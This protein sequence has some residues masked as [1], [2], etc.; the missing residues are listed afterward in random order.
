MRSLGSFSGALALFSV[1]SVSSVFAGGCSSSV[2]TGSPDAGTDSGPAMGGD[3]GGSGD[4][5]GTL[6]FQPSNI[7]IDSVT[8][9]AAMAQPEDIESACTIQTIQA[10]LGSC[11]MSPIVTTT[12]PF[13]AGQTQNVA[14]IVVQSL[15]LGSNAVIAVEGDLPLVIVSLGDV[16]LNSNSSIQAN[17]A[18]ATDELGPG[19]AAAQGNSSTKG[20]GPGGGTAGNTTTNLGAGGGAFCG[21]GGPGGGV[22]APSGMAYGSADVR[23]LQGGSAGGAGTG[24]PGGSG[25]GGGAIQI[26]AMGTLTVNGTAYITAG[27]GGASGCIGFGCSAGGSGGSILLEAMN[28]TIA[29]ILA[30]NGGGGGSNVAGGSDALPLSG[31]TAPTAAPGGAAA[32]GSAAPGGNGSAGA[33]SAGAA[34]G[35]GTLSS[36]NPLGSVPGGGGGGAGW[37]R[38][39]SSSGAATLT[40]GTLSPDATTTCTTQGKVRTISQGP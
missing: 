28:V 31:G 6:A 17:T 2:S 12:E 19:G 40:G 14:L 34:G 32:A 26:V 11:T 3:T 20:A 38:I 16:T 7:T 36:S 27:G 33:M 29:G 5:G 39:N 30:A 18:S 23:P 25:G 24:A 21:L 22:S 15:K 37:I 9:L 10:N 8:A 13:G 35:A 1:V 4:S